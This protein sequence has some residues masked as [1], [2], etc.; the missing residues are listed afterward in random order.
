MI[1]P[2]DYLDILDRE[3]LLEAAGLYETEE[4]FLQDWKADRDLRR[5]FGAETEEIL[6]GAYARAHEEEEE[7]Q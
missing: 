7:K 4:E 1:T 5:R 3:E 6:R 2:F